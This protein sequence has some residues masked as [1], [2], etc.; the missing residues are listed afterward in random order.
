[1]ENRYGSFPSR[2]Q[3]LSGD[4]R[5]PISKEQ[6]ASCPGPSPSTVYICSKLNGHLI[7][8]WGDSGWGFHGLPGSSQQPGS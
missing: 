7:C 1:M 5:R 3:N 6:N 4:H 8:L 2:P